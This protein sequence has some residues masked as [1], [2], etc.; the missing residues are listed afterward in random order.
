MKGRILRL[1]KL[2]KNVYLYLVTKGIDTSV[3]NAI[4]KKHDY[5]H[6][7]YNQKGEEEEIFRE[8]FSE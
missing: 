6:A 8:G 3:Y 1:D 7:I 4:M 5:T 2:H